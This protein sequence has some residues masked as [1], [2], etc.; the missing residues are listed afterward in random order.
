MKFSFET[1]PYHPRK[2]AEESAVASWKD[3][4]RGTCLLASI[5]KRE[6]FVTAQFWIAE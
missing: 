6:G 2:E 1:R 4:E 5:K 3:V